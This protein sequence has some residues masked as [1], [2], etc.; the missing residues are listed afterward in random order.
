MLPED[1]RLE[2]YAHVR[3][4]LARVTEAMTQDEDETDDDVRG[5][6]S[7]RRCLGLFQDRCD[8]EDDKVATYELEEYLHDKKDYSCSVVFELCDFWRAYEKEFP[9][10]SLLFK[11][12][13]CIPKC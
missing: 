10:L 11:C 12:L 1:E 13:L 8:A 7:V 5:P 2:V 6:T 3:E 9:K 4:L